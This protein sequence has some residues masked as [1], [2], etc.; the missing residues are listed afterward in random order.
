VT[1]RLP[2]RLTQGDPFAELSTM[3]GVPEAVEQVRAA[4]DGLRA[5]RVLRRSTGKVSA[6]SMLR[7]A[8]A[9]A[10]LEGADLALDEVR[11]IVRAS[12]RRLEAEEPPS[13][14][15]DVGGPVLAGA[16]RVAA[17]IESLQET[18]RRAPLQVLARLHAL[19]A[20]GQVGADELGRPRPG[21]APRLAAL[22]G[23]LTA[24]SQAPALV[25]SAVVHAEVSTTQAFPVGGGVV[26]RAAGRLVLITRGL[27]PSAV[28]APE[29]G[30][31]ELGQPAYAESLAGYAAG[32]VAG[33]AAWVRHCAEALVLGAR[34]GVAVCEAIQRGA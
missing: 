31:V 7:G 19:A 15:A 6:E 9:S 5:H 4:V 23:L 1:D 27:D 8:R 11:R 20:A 13:T 18:W 25:V 10:A 24:T 29:V 16:L 21:S 3:P 26:A 30:F 34:E 14:G 33:V 32:G 22:A 12:A 2:G 28:C 17:E